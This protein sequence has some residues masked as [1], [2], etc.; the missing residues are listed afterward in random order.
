MKVPDERRVAFVHGRSESF[1]FKTLQL[2]VEAA[3]VDRERPI[4]AISQYTSRQQPSGGLLVTQRA[5]KAL[6]RHF[7]LTF[8]GAGIGF[9]VLKLKLPFLDLFG[10]LQELECYRFNQTN[11]PTHGTSLEHPKRHRQQEKSR[12]ANEV[13]TLQRDQQ[14][15]KAQ[16]SAQ[17]MHQNRFVSECHVAAPEIEKAAL[18]LAMFELPY[19]S[20]TIA[21]ARC[22]RLLAAS[23]DAPKSNA[24]CSAERP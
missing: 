23:S 15:T 7:Y 20:R 4:L 1:L 12:P 5:A 13:I 21:R 2:A 6:C 19:A 8:C 22:R 3:R 9:A 17:Q 11:R 10:A 14:R 18:S 16:N 24:I